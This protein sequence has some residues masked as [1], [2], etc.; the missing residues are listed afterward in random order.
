MLVVSLSYPRVPFLTLCIQT[1][2]LII[3]PRGLSES[4]T[5]TPGPIQRLFLYV[6]PGQSEAQP[7]LMPCQMAVE[8]SLPASCLRT[9][10]LS[11]AVVQAGLCRLGH[12]RALAFTSS[13]CSSEANVRGTDPRTRVATQQQRGLGHLPSSP[14]P[15]PYL[16]HSDRDSTH[17][18]RLLWG[19]N[20]LMNG[21]LLENYLARVFANMIILLILLCNK[22]IR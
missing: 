4:S 22:F 5:M 8:V 7:I 10:H 14:S 18:S 16:G 1:S 20:E 17:H 2:A 12:A 11:P 3:L 13:L 9:P 6:L 15:P 19:L 21:K